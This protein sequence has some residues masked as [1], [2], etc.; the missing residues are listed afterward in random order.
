MQPVEEPLIQGGGTGEF[1]FNHIPAGEDFDV[2]VSDFGLVNDWPQEPDWDILMNLDGGIDPAPL[3]P[4]VIEHGPKPSYHTHHPYEAG[5]WPNSQA[6]A[7]PPNDALMGDTF[8]GTLDGSL[9]SSATHHMEINRVF[10]SAE[11]DTENLH[12]RCDTESASAVSNA[13]TPLSNALPPSGMRT[14]APQPP[15]SGTVPK[16]SMP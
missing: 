2:S 3:S 4:V 5:I 6:S 11:Q 1:D 10:P 14:L 8:S 12:Q 13:D 7:L 16:P 15:T 9:L